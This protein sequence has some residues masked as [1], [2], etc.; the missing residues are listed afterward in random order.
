MRFYIDTCRVIR[1]YGNIKPRE[2]LFDTNLC[3]LTLQFSYFSK[4]S[5]YFP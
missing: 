4:Y 1:H 5:Y 3:E 2:Y